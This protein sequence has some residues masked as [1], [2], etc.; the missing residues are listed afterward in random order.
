MKRSF[1][2]VGAVVIAAAAIY[3]NVLTCRGD[4]DHRRSPESPVGQHLVNG[5]IQTGPAVLGG[6]ERDHILAGTLRLEGQV[7]DEEQRPV[8]GA[9]IHL[10]DQSQLMERRQRKTISNADGSFAF[11]KL[12]T[13]TYILA[14]TKGDASSSYTTRSLTE[15]SDPVILRTHAGATILVHVLEADGKPIEN[16]EVSDSL[17]ETTTG[18]DGT[19]RIQGVQ[20]TFFEGIKVS[21]TGH[22]AASLDLRV[23]DDPSAVIERTVKLARGAPVS[24]IVVGPDGIPVADADVHVETADHPFGESTRTDAQGAWTFAGLGSGKHYFHASSKTYGEVPDL[25]VVLDGQPRTGIVVHVDVDGQLVGTVFDASGKPASGAEIILELPLNAS[26]TETADANGKFSRLGTP[27]GSGIVYAHRGDEASPLTDVELVANRRVEVN[28]V[29]QQAGISGAVVDSHDQP[30]SD[31]R[32]RIHTDDRRTMG[33]SDQITD[34]RG[35]FSFGGVPPGQYE[36]NAMRAEQIK[37]HLY[38]Q[39]KAAAGTHNVKIVLP[40]AAT[41]TG[42]V[43]LDGKPVSYYGLIVTEHPEFSWQEEPRAIR[44]P[45]G[46]FTRQGIAPGTWGIVIAGPRFAR[47][48]ITGIQLS[49][50]K[51]NDLGDIQVD[52]GQRVHGRVTDGNSPV[53]GAIV[54]VAQGVAF[55]DEDNPLRQLSQAK[56][57]AVTADD[58]TYSIEGIAA[59]QRGARSQNRIAAMHPDRGVSTERHLG[60]SETVIDLVIKPAGGIDGAV[61]GVAQPAGIV[62]LERADDDSEA[63][64][65]AD[66]DRDGKFRF[67]HLSPGEYT[68]RVEMLTGASPAAARVT[69]VGA[70]RASVNFV[71][72]H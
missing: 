52:H 50:E 31:A 26:I 19:A 64:L 23:G 1:Y 11:D 46:R 67:D 42:R 71:V 38:G 34:A 65:D 68:V 30:V 60:A 20:T 17:R 58:G 59:D 54:I 2:V 9:Q 45:E 29:M 8:E 24:G 41:V 14:A 63:Q 18:A 21:A 36:L 4:H 25:S 10:V 5:V 32:V 22:A 44:S 66:V 49:E 35:H 43:L 55:E 53:P 47:K 16:A 39:T 7:I 27:L 15:T 6:G 48:V 40:E 12:T 28:L 57:T 70:Q 37:D 62:R 51:I 33:P 69:V 56:I 72:P 13:R 3:V 61:S